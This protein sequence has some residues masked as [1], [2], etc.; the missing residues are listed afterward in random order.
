MTFDTKKARKVFEDRYDHLPTA[1]GDF[2][3]ACDE[4]D[5]LREDVER[6]KAEAKAVDSA[7]NSPK[8]GE[9]DKL[10]A[11]VA[12]R[13]EVLRPA[14]QALRLYVRGSGVNAPAA[15]AFDRFAALAAADKLGRVGETWTQEQIDAAKKRADELDRVLPPIDSGKVGGGT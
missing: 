9:V 4:I 3:A 8:L 2:D 13:D 15:E 12:K 7:L 1:C 10:R 11:E 5:R 14:M 6:W